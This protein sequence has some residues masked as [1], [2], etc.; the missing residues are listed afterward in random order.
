MNK[1]RNVFISFDVDDK[2]M[3][4]LLRW[5]AKDENF[6]FVFKDYSVKE[7]FESAWKS[8]VQYLIY[9]S[10]AVI[11]AIGKHTHKRNAV[12]WEIN[13]AYR[14]DKQIIGVRLHRD[15]MHKIPAA[16]YKYDEITYWDTYEI[17]DILEYE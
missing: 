4:N 1:M 16:S 7:P 11:V 9:R 8:E 17:A 5:Q 14:Q 2:R 15:K 13:E 10:S 6:P 12:I 3:V